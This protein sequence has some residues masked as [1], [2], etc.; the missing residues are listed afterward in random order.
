M[1]SVA[2]LSEVPRATLSGLLGQHHGASNTMAARIATSLGVHPGTL[3]P[4]MA[5]A[6]AVAV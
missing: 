6:E 3:V 1:T 4:S 2:E 5:A